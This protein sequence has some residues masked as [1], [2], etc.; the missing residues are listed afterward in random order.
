MGS[1]QG[2]RFHIISYILVIFYATISI[3]SSLI[4]NGN[5]LIYV[6]KNLKFMPNVKKLWKTWTKINYSNNL[7][8]L[9][10]DSFGII[11]ESVGLRGII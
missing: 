4:Y 2:T 10:C 5:V 1:D 9:A 3:F 6:K 8:I 11:L 7:L